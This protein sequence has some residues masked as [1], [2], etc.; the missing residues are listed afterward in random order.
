M[1]EDILS[2]ATSPTR[3]RAGS[4]EV[5]QEKELYA[6]FDYIEPTFE[7]SEDRFRAVEAD[8]AVRLA[9]LQKKKSF[10]AKQDVGKASKALQ[11]E[12]AEKLRL[13]GQQKLK[14]DSEAARLKAIEEAKEAEKARVE[15]Q[16]KEKIEA[17]RKLYWD[18]A[19]SVLN[20]YNTN[21]EKNLK[22]LKNLRKK[23]RDITDL[24]AKIAQSGVKITAEQRE[25]LSRKADIDDEIADLEEAEQKALNNAPIFDS[26]IPRPSAE[27]DDSSCNMVFQ[28][29]AAA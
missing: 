27:F 5:T 16:R 28:N 25:K 12:N 11:V 9:K 13:Q 24:E 18:W 10:K 4:G 14:E 20:D 3:S 23:L 26:S 29:A 7:F 15:R 8:L 1:I 2:C 19:D 21:L 17:E 6:G 22:K